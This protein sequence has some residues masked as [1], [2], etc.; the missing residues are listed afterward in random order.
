MGN[1]D[2]RA[3]AT[4]GWICPQ[5]RVETNQPHQTPGF[6]ANEEGQGDKHEATF[7]D[8][9]FQEKGCSGSVNCGETTSIILKNK[10]AGSQMSWHPAL[11]VGTVRSQWTRMRRKHLP[12]MPTLDHLVAD[13]ASL[14]VLSVSLTGERD[15][16]DP[17]THFWTL[18]HVWCYLWLIF[19]KDCQ[20]KKKS[21]TVF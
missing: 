12:E 3:R 18:L 7:S 8:S 14:L 16:T 15:A 5:V 11:K 20:K 1:S 21:R 17:V 9:A 10:H 6:W 2:S 13:V 19:W 4:L